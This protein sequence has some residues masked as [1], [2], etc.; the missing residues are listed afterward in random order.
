[1]KNSRKNTA[2]VPSEKN[3]DERNPLRIRSGLSAPIFCAVKLD[4]PFPMVVKQVIA[5]VFSLM[6]AE[7][8]ATM[9]EPYPLTM[10]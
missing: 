10:Y 9:E 4:M 1:M 3:S 7:Y 5:K 6:A 2:A 8:P